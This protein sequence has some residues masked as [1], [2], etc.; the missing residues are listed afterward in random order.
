MTA[1]VSGSEFGRKAAVRI[2]IFL[3]LTLGFPFIVYGLIV[4]TG[5]RSI[6]GASGA[7]AVV[8]GIYLTPVI[9]G[10]FILSMILPCWRRMRSLGLP[11][12]WGLIIPLLF[13]MDGAALILIGAHWASR[14]RSESC[15]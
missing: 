12:W 5:A 15:I 3:V 9:V 4:A 11:S 13:L 8:A 2:G 10:A 1:F 6:G 14:F 7:L